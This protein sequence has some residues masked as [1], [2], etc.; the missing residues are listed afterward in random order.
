[1]KQFIKDF[2]L[3]VLTAYVFWVLAFILIDYIS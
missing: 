2:S 3:A 1:M